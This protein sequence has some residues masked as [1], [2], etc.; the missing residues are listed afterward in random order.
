ML[1]KKCSIIICRADFLLETK[2][3]IQIFFKPM[4]LFFNKLRISAFKPYN[5]RVFDYKL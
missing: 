1:N 5:D 4:Y 3:L 2:Q